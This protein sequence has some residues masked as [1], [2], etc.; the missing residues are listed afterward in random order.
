MRKFSFFFVFLIF[1]LEFFHGESFFTTSGINSSFSVKGS[2][3]VGRPDGLFRI[4]GN[5]EE[6]LWQEGEVQ[7]ILFAQNTY[8]FLTSVGIFKSNDLTNFVSCNNGLPTNVIKTL[9]EGKTSFFT[10]TQ[11]IKDLKIHPTDSNIL[12]CATK[13]AVYLSRDGA[14]SWRNIGS[15]SRSPGIKAVAV[16]TL[17]NPNSG[18][19]ELVAFVSHSIWSLGYCKPDISTKWTDI[20]AG[21]DYLDT[22]KTIDEVSDIIAVE[23][24]GNTEI[25]VTQTFRPCLYR[26]NWQKC[27]GELLW[28]GGM[29]ADAIDGLV[30][31][32]NTVLFSRL[33]GMGEYSFSKKSTALYEPSIFRKLGIFDSGKQVFSALIPVASHGEIKNLTFSALHLLHP[34]RNKSKFYEKASHK[35]GL[36][37][38]ANQVATQE[39]IDKYISIMEKNDLNALVIDMKD[40]LGTLR[41]KSS[42]PIVQKYGRTSKFAIDAPNFIK[43]MKAK[44]KY[45]IARIVVF[46]DPHL[47]TVNNGKF[48]VWNY[49]TK[50]PWQGIQSWEDEFIE[51][52][53]SATSPMEKKVGEEAEVKKIPTGNKVP[54]YFEE[55]W[56]D[57]HSTEVWEYNIAIALE[58]INLGF[59]EIQFDYIRFPTDGLNLGE[60]SYRFRERGMDMESAILSFLTYARKMIDAPIGIDIYGANGFYR[61]GLRTGQDVELLLNF[62]DVISPM[63][64]PSHFEQTFMAQQPPEE[65]PYRIFYLGVFRNAIIAR[66]KAVIRP[67]LQAFY[68]NVSYDKVY[69]NNDYVRRQVFGVRDALN[70]GY[71]FWNNSGRY[72]DICPPPSLSEPY[73][74]DAGTSG[75]RRPLIR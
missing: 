64:Y 21:F 25:Y 15:N 11:S 29:I 40:D 30:H 57:P 59:D 63:F 58:L 69:Y 42:D 7:K 35:Q 60:I 66:N 4:S 74:W 20:L 36:Y 33:Y 47:Y 22:A 26:L 1:S 13:D 19:K 28:R 48:A 65:R 5:R 34:D 37:V 27:A 75:F 70:R 46:K 16:A 73:P 54:K 50:G 62:V 52:P 68:L 2:I 3:L 49:K 18:A 41:Y 44:G 32:G 9:D 10:R 45:L 61:S 55:Y 14:A 71:L 38:P 53:N 23:K 6:Q 43:Q 8:F 39:G 12:V 56:V 24:N 17:K 67:W 51:D 31:T 72:D